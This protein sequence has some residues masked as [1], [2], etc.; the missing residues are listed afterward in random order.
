MW[1]GYRNINS[2]MWLILPDNA[3]KWEKINEDG[4]K[5]KHIMA[6]WFT[7]LDTNKRHEDLIL[8]KQYNTDEYPAY[9]NYNAI[10]IDKV[11]DI[12][13]DYNGVMGVPITYLDKY[14]PSQFEIIG[15]FN[16]YKPETADI[17]KGQIYGE[18]VP[19]SSTTSLF[20]GPVINGQAK[21]FRI[22]IKKRS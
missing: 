5:I 15:C 14:N 9:D 18:A 11:T 6:C 3:E 7:N 12:P 8:Y 4:K 17:E 16:N 1:L 2:D 19:V 22:L 13:V 21:Y 10:N 20:R